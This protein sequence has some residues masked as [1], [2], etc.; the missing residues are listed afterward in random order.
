MKR[1]TALAG[2]SLLGLLA[3]T[4]ILAEEIT[5]S[6]W[7]PDTHPLTRDG[8]VPLAKEL[9]ERS[10]GSLTMK[11]YTGTALLPPVAHL[12]GLTDGWCR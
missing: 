2:A 12:S 8:Y 11:L 1:L 4:P 3:A 7:F 10:D 5:A 6:I 9:E